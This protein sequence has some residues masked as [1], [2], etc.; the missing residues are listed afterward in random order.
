MVG[1]GIDLIQY[2]PECITPVPLLQLRGYELAITDR[3]SIQ[4]G[5]AAQASGSLFTATSTS[6]P[7][8]FCRMRVGLILQ[9]KTRRTNRGAGR[10]GYRSFEVGHGAQSFVSLRLLVKCRNDGLERSKEVVNPLSVVHCVVPSLAFSLSGVL[11]L[12]ICARLGSAACGAAIDLSCTSIRLTGLNGN[13]V[14]GNAGM[15][16][17]FLKLPLLNMLGHL[18]LELKI[19]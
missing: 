15:C 2:I 12:V 1:G 14:N 5:S 19:S 16:H 7:L 18:S 11:L 4:A 8:S 13:L 10:Y 6:E 17:W 3:T 9:L